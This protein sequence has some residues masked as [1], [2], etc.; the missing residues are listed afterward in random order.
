MGFCMLDDIT[1]RLHREQIHGLHLGVTTRARAKA[2]DATDV[3][4]AMRGDHWG[5]E[6]DAHWEALV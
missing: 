3:D 1:D 4:N 2:E 6:W 5:S